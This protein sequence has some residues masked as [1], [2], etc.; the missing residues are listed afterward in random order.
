[1]LFKLLKRHSAVEDFEVDIVEDVRMEFGEF[2]KRIMKQCCPESG[3]I[4]SVDIYSNDAVSVA[5]S[6]GVGVADGYFLVLD[7][8]REKIGVDYSNGLV[9]VIS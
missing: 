5:S 1:M 6:G 4:I 9:W 3:G 8:E 2:I 7:V